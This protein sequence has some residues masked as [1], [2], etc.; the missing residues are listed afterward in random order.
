MVF[1]RLPFDKGTKNEIKKSIINDVIVFPANDL[2]Y[3][4]NISSPFIISLI[5]ECLERNTDN[6]PTIKKILEKYVEKYNEDE[7]DY[8]I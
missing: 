2:Y 1:K 3:N 8:Y 6:R 4:N 5:T 7:E